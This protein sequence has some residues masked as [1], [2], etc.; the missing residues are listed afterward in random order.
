MDASEDKTSKFFLFIDLKARN[1]RN[2]ISSSISDGV[3]VAHKAMAP[4]YYENLFDQSSYRNVFPK[5]IV[6]KS[7]ELSALLNFKLLIL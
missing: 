2:Q 4:S 5:L 6:K 3:R 1:A 7:I